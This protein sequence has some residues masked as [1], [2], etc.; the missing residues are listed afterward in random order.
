MV[1]HGTPEGY[2][3]G[4]RSR[5]GCQHHGSSEILTCVDAHIAR[6]ADFRLSRLPATTRLR[7]V[8]LTAAPSLTPPPAEA[9]AAPAVALPVHGTVWGYRR[10]CRGHRECPQWRAGLRTCV[11]AKRSYA[12]EYAKSRGRGR[13]APIPHGTNA[14]YFAGCRNRD[15]CEK[16][17]S[18]VTCADARNTHKRVL[19]R[20]AGTPERETLVDAGHAATRI[21]A[22]Q[23]HGYSLRKI[24]ELTG[25]G[26]STVIAIAGGTDAR[27]S[28]SKVT[29]ATLSAI[30][31]IGM[32]TDEAPPLPVV[33][34][35]APHGR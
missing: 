21:V 18:G 25:V 29:S 34:A 19:S 26:R 13:G 27:S 12:T 7:R 24:A 33:S 8:V 14:G 31:A 1:L 9:A 17:E 11:E 10:G 35:E 30:L 22:W 15:T 23:A 5:G 20:R 28:R 2:A 4:C 3:Q 16:D 32:P 6:Q